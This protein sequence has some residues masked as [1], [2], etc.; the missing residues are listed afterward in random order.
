MQF[1]MNYGW[2]LV[3]SSKDEES[4]VSHSE[5]IKRALGL[6]HENDPN[7]DKNKI[8]FSMEANI[9]HIFTEIEKVQM[10]FLMLNSKYE[11][12]NLSGFKI[13]GSLSSNPVFDMGA[14]MDKIGLRSIM[15]STEEDFDFEV[16][17]NIFYRNSKI[18]FPKAVEATKAHIIKMKKE[19]SP[20]KAKGIKP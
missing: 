2:N 15:G 18:A 7:K 19:N 11:L 6:S 4:A 5:T 9:E 10:L 20:K 12:A 8:A 14:G 1:N 16:K 13:N 17:D 3:V